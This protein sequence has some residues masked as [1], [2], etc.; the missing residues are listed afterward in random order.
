[1]V[2]FHATAQRDTQQ[3]VTQIDI[4]AIL[5]IDSGRVTMY[6]GR[7]SD[8]CFTDIVSD[9][10]TRLIQYMT[11][12]QAL[13]GVYMESLSPVFLTNL[14]FTISGKYL[15]KTYLTITDYVH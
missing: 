9:A 5:A 11:L 7:K 13:G 4:S 10:W 15:I 2:S 6:I 14:Y 12:R 8:L 1:M 3:S